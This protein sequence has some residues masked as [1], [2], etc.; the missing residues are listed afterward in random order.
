VLARSGTVISDQNAASDYVRFYHPSQCQ[1]LV[2]DDIFA[3]DWRHPND[4]IA[5]WRHKARK[6]AEV[7]VPQRVETRFVIGVYVVDSATSAA[8]SSAGLN[9][10]VTVNPGIFFR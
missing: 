5:Y 3:L 1:N 10:S 8:L 4:P 6:C 7:L 2:F 9:E